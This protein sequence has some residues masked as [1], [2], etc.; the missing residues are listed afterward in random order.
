MMPPGPQDVERAAQGGLVAR[1]LEEN[2][3]S[4]LVLRVGRQASGILG[5]IDRVARRRPRARD[6]G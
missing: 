4:P 5:D 2:V 1:R 3:E 6:S